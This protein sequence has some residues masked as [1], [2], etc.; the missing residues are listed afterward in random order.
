MTSVSVRASSERTSAA[1]VVRCAMRHSLL[2]TALLFAAAQAAAQPAPIGDAE[3][4]ARR[5]ALV[6]ALPA[7][8]A[9]VA[10]GERDEIG[11]PAFYQ[12]PNFRYLT[13]LDEPNAVLLLT[14]GPRAQGT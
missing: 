9:L 13:G 12:S 11:F 3:F 6:A 7:E 8:A 10:F 5:D 14:H 2:P 1:S 4:R